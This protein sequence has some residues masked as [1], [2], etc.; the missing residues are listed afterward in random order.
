M[1]DYNEIEVHDL[2]ATDIEVW[3]YQNHASFWSNEAVID[4]N[5]ISHIIAYNLVITISSWAAL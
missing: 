2:T 1:G 3:L 5:I 4:A